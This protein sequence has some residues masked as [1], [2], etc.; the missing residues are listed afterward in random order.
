MANNPYT[1]AADLA[2]LIWEAEMVADHFADGNLM[3]VRTAEGWRAFLHSFTADIRKLEAELDKNVPSMEKAYLGT[4]ER[5]S[6]LVEELHTFLP[7]CMC[8]PGYRPMKFSD[9]EET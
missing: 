3:L 6:N 9:E 2:G 5:G 8:F 1:D 7:N 4:V